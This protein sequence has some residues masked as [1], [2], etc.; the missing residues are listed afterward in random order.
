MD[1]RYSSAV[2][3]GGQERR[4]RLLDQLLVAALQRAVPG[5]DHRHVPVAVGET[6]G[7]HVPRPVQVALDEALAAPERRHGLADRGLV[8][9]DDPGL[10]ADHLQAP[11][12]AAER[13]LDGDGQ[14]V[15]G[16]ERLDL[17]HAADRAVRARRHGG[18][19]GRGDPPCG[20][21]VAQGLDR[22]RRR[23]DPDQPGVQDRLGETGVLGQ[24]T[25]AGVDGIGPGLGRHGEDLLD[26]E[27][28]L[29]RGRAAE[30]VRLV[31]HRDVQRVEVGFGVDGHTLQPGVPA[32]PHD[33]DRDLTTVRDQHFAHESSPPDCRGV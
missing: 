27:V 10:V 24:E 20:H 13:G 17:V 21:L 4:G 19:D 26:A 31:G 18:A 16:H 25:V 15:A 23:P 2:W 8:R 14:A 6:L 5:G 9:L 11:A 22:G 30:R 29:G 3:S 33:A 1:A 32:G 7:L 12:A 28:A